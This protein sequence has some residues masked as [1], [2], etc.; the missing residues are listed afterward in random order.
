MRWPNGSTEQWSDVKADQVLTLT[1]GTG[2]SVINR[3]N[4][5]FTAV[6][7]MPE[8]RDILFKQGLDAA[9]S[10]PEAFGAYI[11]SEIDK[12]GPLIK[13]AGVTVE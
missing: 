7:K 12:W 6:L 13:K 2:P 1:E 11:K 5:E 4:Q 10:T 9:P 3:L 8:I